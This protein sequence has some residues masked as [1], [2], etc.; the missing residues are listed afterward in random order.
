[1]AMWH[2]ECGNGGKGNL[3]VL[4][5]FPPTL[6]LQ[7]HLY[8]HFQRHQEHQFLP[9]SSA[10]KSL[11]GSPHSMLAGGFVHLVC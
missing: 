9:W 3:P 6:L 10:S 5:L 7:P 11:W 4:Y 2:R 8:S 1:M